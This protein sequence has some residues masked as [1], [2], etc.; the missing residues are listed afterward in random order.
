MADLS[1]QASKH[2]HASM[3]LGTCLALAFAGIWITDNAIL[4][5]IQPPGNHLS[6]RIASLIVYLAAYL[7]S[8]AISQTRKDTVSLNSSIRKQIALLVGCGY[9]LFVLGA[10]S[11]LDGSTFAGSDLALAPLALMK[12]TGPF[13]SI[14][15]LLLFATLERRCAANAAALGMTSAFVLESVTKMATSSI[16]WGPEALL[17]IGGAY[18]AAAVA[19]TTR[20]LLNQQQE[21]DSTTISADASNVKPLGSILDGKTIIF[22]A[23]TVIVLGFLRTG[24]HTDSSI[25]A[26][27]AIM[28]L[29]AVALATW[30]LSLPDTQELYRAAIVCTAAGFLLGPT[31]AAVSPGSS[32]LLVGVGTALF[33]IVI[34]T[35]STD[36]TRSCD[37]RLR[38][39]A[40]MRLI[41]VVGHLLGTLIA[42]VSTVA[43]SIFPKAQEAA[44]LVVVFLYV[45]MLL[46]LWNESSLCHFSGNKK[47]K[48]SKPALDNS[49]DQA[50][51]KQPCAA[52]A[53]RSGL[54]P[55]ETDVLE[56]LA[57]G[58]D[59]AFMEKRFVLSRNTVKMHVKHVY[60]KLDV[61]SKQEVIDLVDT[62]RIWSK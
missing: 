55:R 22:I 12:C 52:L 34:W 58:R 21:K 14:A 59:L 44:S 53:E 37:N 13:L 39:A 1:K 19:F 47:S 48:T 10:H 51:W 3:L 9:V 40:A 8:I 57:Q 28:I 16:G 4:T 46:Y 42:A 7:A 11:A 5:L 54:T 43:I 56:Q 18:L 32:V 17:G 20:A 41:V 60:A 50:Y 62:E 38:T 25:D 45:L 49:L 31:L 2:S 61:H 23:G 35:V 27:P 26:L 33:E 30:R 15:I 6:V 36:I 29:I 24:D